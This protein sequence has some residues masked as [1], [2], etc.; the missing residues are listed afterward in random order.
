MAP[1][2]AKKVSNQKFEFLPPFFIPNDK[3]EKDELIFWFETIF[4]VLGAISGL[5]IVAIISFGHIPT[6][7]VTTDI[8]RISPKLL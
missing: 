8:I 1:K 3:E 7:I 6:I 2:T 4:A 5:F